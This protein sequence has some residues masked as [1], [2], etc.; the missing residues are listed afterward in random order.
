[1]PNHLTSAVLME[2]F[3]NEGENAL[4]L[5]FE[6]TVPASVTEHLHQ[7]KKCHQG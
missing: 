1:M 4:G 2:Q 3:M 7:C 5:S 6:C